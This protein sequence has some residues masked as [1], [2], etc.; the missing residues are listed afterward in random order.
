ML[1]IIAQNLGV[2]IKYFGITNV[3]SRVENIF[4]FLAVWL[5]VLLNP[6]LSFVYMMGGNAVWPVVLRDIFVIVFLFL[7]LSTTKRNVIIIYSVVFLTILGI[8]LQL[9]FLSDIS[10]SITDYYFVLRGICILLLLSTLSI[11]REVSEFLTDM[12][13]KAFYAICLLGFVELCIESISPG[14]F[15]TSVLM[16]P[17]YFAIKGTIANTNSGWLAETRIVSIFYS[18][19]SFGLFL[20][21]SIASIIGSK[22]VTGK[23]LRNIILLVLLLL[24]GSAG[25]IGIVVLVLAVIYQMRYRRYFNVAASGIFFISLGV[26]SFAV[27]SSIESTVE[28]TASAFHHIG[29]LISGIDVTLSSPLGVGPKEAGV[30]GTY[31]SSNE[32]IKA[33][34]ESLTGFIAAAL[35][36]VGL[37]IVLLSHSS[38]LFRFLIEHNPIMRE[39][40]FVLFLFLFEVMF[41]ENSSNPNIWVIPFLLLISKPCLVE[42]RI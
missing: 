18:P 31:L 14:Q 22:I 20:G 26:L 1:K 16:L 7:Y 4:G 34:D 8:A 27:S 41:N 10:L 17:D 5:C 21:A 37:L 12:A 30:T 32:S 13:L 24:L 15:Q 2:K 25:K 40:R 11:N 29:G 39:K 36:F 33:G 35:G 23:R 19:S 6:L 3:G 9:L 28:H 38:V 42:R